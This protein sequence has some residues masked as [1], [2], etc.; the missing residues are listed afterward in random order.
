[1][2]W[3]DWTTQSWSEDFHGGYPTVVPSKFMDED[4]KGGWIISSLP[5]QSFDG[6]FYSF[7]MRRFELTVQDMEE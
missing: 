7:G 6:Q 3:R 2:G 4:G 5:I 1:M